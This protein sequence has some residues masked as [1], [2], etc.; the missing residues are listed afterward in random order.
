[1]KKENFKV[2][3]NSEREFWKKIMH[4]SKS[5]LTITLLPDSVS[6]LSM[7]AKPVSVH[8]KKS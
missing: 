5:A 1:M 8:L 2:R 6:E 4:G 7:F 3:D